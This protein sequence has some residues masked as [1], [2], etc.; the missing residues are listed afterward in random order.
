MLPA[1]AH[2]AVR[3]TIG[4]MIDLFLG[5]SDPA[6]QGDPFNHKFTVHSEVR[7]SIFHNLSC[8]A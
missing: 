6:S 5:K 8:I 2:D 7:G 1:E 4:F 3:T